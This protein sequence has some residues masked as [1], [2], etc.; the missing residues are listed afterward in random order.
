MTDHVDVA[1]GI[2][3]EDRAGRGPC[4]L[5]CRRPDGAILGGYWEFPGGK[6]EAGETP[7]Q[8]LKREFSEELG[9]DIVVGKPM[10]TI[11]HEYD[12][13]RVRLHPFRC[14]R[15]A[16]EPQNR[17]VAEHRWVGSADF[18]GLRFPPANAGLMV[19]AEQ[20]L[21]RGRPDRV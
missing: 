21:A 15:R 4:M 6:I 19:E 11:E 14:S 12:H 10:A 13:G 16:C 20:M 2:L 18:E 9:V 17:Q 5:V 3:I 1:V 8:C 7:A